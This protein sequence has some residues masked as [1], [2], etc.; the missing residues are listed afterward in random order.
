MENRKADTT[1]VVNGKASLILAALGELRGAV[2]GVK[3]ELAEVKGK[4]A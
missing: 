4:K 2:E 1:A 3:R